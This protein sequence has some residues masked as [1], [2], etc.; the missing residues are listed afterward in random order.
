VRLEGSAAMGRLKL[1]SEP[2]AKA[3]FEVKVARLVNPT[4]KHKK[5]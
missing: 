5:I 4:V 2:V 3:L 1:M